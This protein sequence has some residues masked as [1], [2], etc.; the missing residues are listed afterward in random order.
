LQDDHIR[1][2]ESDIRMWIS[3]RFVVVR[4]IFGEY[5]SFE[6]EKKGSL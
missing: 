4:R 2:H 6:F 5:L 3:G 1:V